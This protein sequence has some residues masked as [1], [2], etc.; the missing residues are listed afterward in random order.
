MGLE[1]PTTAEIDATIIAQLQAT[2]DQDVPLLPKAFLRVLSR[3]LAG[4]FILLY[5][6]TGFMFLQMFVRTA[7]IEETDI[8]G[9]LIS[10]L[11][12]WGRLI[13]VGDPA[14][15]T[16]AELEIEITVNNQ[17]G[18]LPSQT[19]LVGALNGVT[20]H[21]I[22]AVVL[23]AATVNVNVRAVSDQAGGDGSGA[24]GN[25]DVSDEMSFANPLAN[26]ERTTTVTTVI[27]TGADAEATEAY[28][29]RVLD[30]FQKRPQGG[31]YADY[32]QWAEE[33][34]GILN[35][36][37]YTAV[38]PGQV[39]IYIEATVESSGD[40]DGF[41]TAAQLQ[42]ALDAT[43]F[44]PSGVPNR[45]PANALSNTFSI[46][47][48]EFNVEITG[49]AVDNPGQTQQ[50]IEDALTEYFLDRGPF[51]VGLTIP[52]RKDRITGPAV[53]GIVDDIVSA[54]NGIFTSAVIDQGGGPITLFELGVG[55]KAKVGTV[56]F[57]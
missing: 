44:D 39:D 30:R 48:E 28:R 35:A 46:T 22:G 29:Q 41:P 47:R 11:I 25:L 45:R 33:P 36:Y 9:V 37:P 53:T 7:T 32:E 43:I 42:E 20:Y 5:K 26:V 54:V 21:T 51:I 8:N 56:S 16:R 49:L 52:P 6:Y 3:T 2:L 31:A 15:A 14:S 19:Q 17:V 10:P 34:A 12:A 18:T 50:D 4:V 38:D 27:T 40:P 24:I 13:G 57:V 55:E 1:T 23:N